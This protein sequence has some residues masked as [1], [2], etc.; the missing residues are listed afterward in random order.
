MKFWKALVSDY[1]WWV[2]MAVLFFIELVICMAI[3]FVKS[4]LLF[5]AGFWLPAPLY[6][7]ILVYRK[8]QKE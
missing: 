5:A 3:G 1:P 8:K 6:Y 7:Y 2:I 4:P